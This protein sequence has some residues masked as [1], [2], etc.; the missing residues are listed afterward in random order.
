[1]IR[2]S[3][4]RQNDTTDSRKL[5]CF[6]TRLDTQLAASEGRRACKRILHKNKY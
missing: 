3:A 1:M 6:G 4:A 5:I 2:K